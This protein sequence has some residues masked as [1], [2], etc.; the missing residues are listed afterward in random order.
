MRLAAISD[1]HGNLP[2]LQAVLADIG[3]RGT[4]LLVN[5]GDCVSGPLWPS[6]TADL[7]MSL[8]I[9]TIAGNHERQL[10]APETEK[11]SMSDRFAR[12]ALS[13][14]QL[15]WIASLPPTMRL[16]DDVFLCHGTPDSDLDYLLETVTPEGRRRAHIDEIERRLG[17]RGA[18][19]VLCGHSHT[20]RLTRLGDGSLVANPGSVGL[21]AFRWGRPF[22]HEVSTGSPLARFGFFERVDGVWTGEIVAV[23]YAV[24]EAA[25]KAE[26]SGSLDWA[27]VLE[28][29]RI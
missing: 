13:D 29:G 21:Q 15:E 6:E 11:M 16:G 10:L 12:Q 7:L 1:V 18:A 27:R 3:H 14:G 22:P 24:A 4:D 23:E 19:L 17:G 25:R 20:P 8:D 9:P 5:L 26:R 28:T 2:A